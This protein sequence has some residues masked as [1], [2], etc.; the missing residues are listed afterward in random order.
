M[1]KKTEKADPEFT[2]K[3]GS[4]EQQ[5]AR[6]PGTITSRAAS[7]ALV[8]SVNLA[9]GASQHTPLV[10]DC[11]CGRQTSPL[12]PQYR[13]RLA[14]PAPSK[15][16]ARQSKQEVQEPRW[17]KSAFMSALESFSLIT[18]IMESLP[19]ASMLVFLKYQKAGG[20]TWCLWWSVVPLAA[21][22][23]L[24]SPACGLDVA[25]GTSSQPPAPPLPPQMHFFSTCQY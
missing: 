15:A 1:K 14:M 4:C 16:E 18:I 21:L 3:H 20:S 22:S 2:A 13:P 19:F 5:W 23:S 6:Q 9:W 24:H 12:S 10:P 25:P 17:A 11:L 8:S 7:L